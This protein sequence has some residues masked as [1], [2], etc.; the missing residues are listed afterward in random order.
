MARNRRQHDEG[1]CFAVPLEGGG[2]ALGVLARTSAG[3]GVVFGYFF[4][5]KRDALP[6]ADELPRLAPEDAIWSGR[7]GDLELV[8]GNWPV[9]GKLPDWRREEWPMP[10]FCMGADHGPWFRVRYSDEDANV[11]ESATQIAQEECEGLPPDAMYGAGAVEVVL[12]SHL[13]EGGPVA[14][15]G[16]EPR[17]GDRPEIRCFL[18]FA[19][20]DAARSATKTLEAEDWGV[21]HEE[22]DGEDD[23]VLCAR[24]FGAD[25]LDDE[26]DSIERRMEE[27]ASSLGGEYDGFEREVI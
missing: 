21:L 18:Y 16:D 26:L 15:A 13:G 2:H 1:T 19:S 6:A 8:E 20:R 25:E 14:T 27:L 9:L 24:R 22:R 10:E 11:E 12:S 23:L 17:P 7:F 3:S 5:P 4:G